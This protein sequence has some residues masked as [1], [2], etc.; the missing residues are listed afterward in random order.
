MTRASAR[1]GAAGAAM[2]RARRAVSIV[3]FVNG[4]VLASWVAH[5]PALAT[6]LAAVVGFGLVGLGIANVIPVLFSAAGRVSGVAPATA[7]AAVATTGYGGYLAGPPLIGFVAELASLPAAL[8]IIS[9]ACALIAVGGGAQP[10][11]RRLLPLDS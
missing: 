3:F 5:I 2:A 8:G 11:E 6:P 10:Q 9:A 1:A 7:L 4:V